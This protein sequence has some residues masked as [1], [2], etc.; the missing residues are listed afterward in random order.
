[1][2]CHYKN[3]DVIEVTEDPTVLEHLKD[4]NCIIE[5]GVTIRFY[6]NESDKNRCGRM[7]KKCQKYECNE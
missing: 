1:M 5:E 6:V 7:K 2:D 4:P 3:G